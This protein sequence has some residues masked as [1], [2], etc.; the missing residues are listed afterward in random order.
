[1]QITHAFFIFLYLKTCK[2]PSV[3]SNFVMISS[4]SGDVKGEE[5][6]QSSARVTGVD[7]YKENGVF[8]V[9]KGENSKVEG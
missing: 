3:S 2:E 7:K 5:W 4:I 6:R 1:M 9:K 8:K